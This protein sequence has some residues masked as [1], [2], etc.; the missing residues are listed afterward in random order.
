MYCMPIGLCLSDNVE[1]GNAHLPRPFPR[2]FFRLSTPPHRD[3]PAVGL[4]ISLHFSALSAFSCASLH[5]Q[6]NEKDLGR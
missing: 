5:A 6:E 2:R 1:V 4:V 3:F